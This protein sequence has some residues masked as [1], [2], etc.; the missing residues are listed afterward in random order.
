M[1]LGLQPV[2]YSSTHRVEIVDLKKMNHSISRILILI[3]IIIIS[4]GEKWY[5]ATLIENRSHSSP[6]QLLPFR[7]NNIPDA[8]DRYMPLSTSDIRKENEWQD[9][10]RTQDGNVNTFLFNSYG[11]Y[12]KDREPYDTQNGTLFKATS[13]FNF[14]VTDTVSMR[15]PAYNSSLNKNTQIRR[16]IVRKRCPALRPRQKKHLSAKET[17]TRFLEIFEVVEFDHVPCT[18]SS[19]LEGTCLHESDCRVA[20]G[21]TMGTCADGYGSCCVSKYLPNLALCFSVT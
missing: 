11:A 20:G 7:T 12:R 21:A 5:P 3:S 10:R 19:G 9:L 13:K 14:N 2:P 8:E 1:H 18:S 6:E 17:K 16:K 15:K 4:D